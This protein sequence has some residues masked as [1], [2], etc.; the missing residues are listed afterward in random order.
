MCKT[1]AATITF[2]LVAVCCLALGAW[3]FGKVIE[4]QRILRVM[5]LPIS[6][7]HGQPSYKRIASFGPEAVPVVCMEIAEEWERRADA[8]STISQ[9]I[10]ALSAI[11][12][13]RAVPTLIALADH[14]SPSIRRSAALGLA[15]VGDARCLPAL[16]RLARDEEPTVRN[17]ARFAMECITEPDSMGQREE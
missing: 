15:G 12:D 8:A 2:G 6:E 1:R 16:K 4:R 10:V 17:L 14:E 5:Y 3:G 7:R 13:S 11:G 9:W